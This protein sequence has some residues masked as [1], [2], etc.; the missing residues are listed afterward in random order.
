MFSEQYVEIIE[1]EQYDISD[2]PK[3]LSRYLYTDLI[4]I[5]SSYINRYTIDDHPYK[6]LD[7]Y[8]DNYDGDLI[9]TFRMA[10]VNNSLDV[11]VFLNLRGL[12]L[13]KAQ[14]KTNI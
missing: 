3:L 7:Q 1:N 11:V 2:I 6:T 8:F 4:G 12:L 5:C 13:K 14:K 9:G 10:F